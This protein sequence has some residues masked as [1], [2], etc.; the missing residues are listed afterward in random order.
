MNNIQLLS[1]LVNKPGPTLNSIKLMRL[2]GTK[3]P[4]LKMV[5]SALLNQPTNTVHQYMVETEKVPTPSPTK[6]CQDMLEL[7][8][9][10]TL[11]P[12]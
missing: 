1:I 2:P 7:S 5:E 8:L 9:K 4:S 3:K 6:E 11:K 12:N 10:R